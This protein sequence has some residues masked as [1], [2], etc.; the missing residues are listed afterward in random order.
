M[1]YD[2]AMKNCIFRFLSGSHA[3]GMNTEQS[4]F[5]HRAVFIAPVSK[6]F[7]LFQTSFVGSGST[8]Q[9]LHEALDRIDL[10]L[11]E[12]AKECIKKALEID[13]GD[14]K[15]NVE[16]IDAP[17]S[18]G[19]EQAHELRKFM[20]LAAECNPNIVEFLY[21]EKGITHTS[22]EW[23]RIRDN[24]SIF[25]SKKARFTFGRYAAAQLRRIETHRG[26][27]LNPPG[28]KPSRASFGLPAEGKI[29]TEVE[30]A[31]IG[32][33]TEWV[34][35]EARDLVSKERAYHHKLGEWKSYQEWASNRNEKRRELERKHS[36]DTKHAS[37]LVR[38]LRMAKE[39]LTT[40]QVL[41]HRPDAAELLSIRNGAWPFEKVKEY[42][43]AMELEL[44]SLL[45]TTSLPQNP[46]WQGISDL[47]KSIC[48]GRYGI[49][50]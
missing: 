30:K 47:Y 13:K 41:V 18:A 35:P 7:E 16:T 5:D 14:L 31:I 8:Y 11:L 15:T 37:H 44:D 26:Y 4:D 38:L 36:F 12:G 29:S 39:I 3:Y 17:K 49:E 22:P 43:E 40:G 25:L 10:G 28:E 9:N 45:K 32:M 34:R 2:E 6:A 23:E 24:R 21:V 50:I 46:D 20:K 42:A 1:T 48:R 33:P 19:D 27:L